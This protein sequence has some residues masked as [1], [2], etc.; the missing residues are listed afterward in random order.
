M[1]ENWQ[2]FMVWPMQGT[3]VF[4]AYNRSVNMPLSS[5]DTHSAPRVPFNPVQPFNTVL[6]GIQGQLPFPD[7]DFDLL[8]I[9][10][11]NGFG[12]PSPGHTTFTSQLGRRL[13]GGQLL[14]HHLPDRLHR[15]ARW[16]LRRDVGEHDAHLPVRNVPQRPDADA[17]RH[18]GETQDAVPLT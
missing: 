8:R 2:S 17:Q 13:G 1:Q 4:A 12:M 3:G 10:A 5:G 6:W 18:L 14:R 11:G 15:Q 9:T 16:P 7:P